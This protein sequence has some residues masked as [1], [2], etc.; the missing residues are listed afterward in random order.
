[1][2][3]NPKN[4]DDRCF[5][6]AAMVPLDYGEIKSNP[7]RISNI[8]P[9]INKYSWDKIKY[10][11]KIGDWKTFEKNNSTVALNFLYTREMEMELCP[12]YIPKNNS[13]REKQITF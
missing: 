7:E 8:K 5:Q 1:M 10:S 13:N 4:K 11:L 9:F 3:I 2:T 6:Y 12:A